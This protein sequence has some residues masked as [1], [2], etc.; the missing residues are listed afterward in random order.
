MGTPK[1]HFENVL[2]VAQRISSGENAVN[3]LLAYAR[4]VGREFAYEYFL[5]RIAPDRGA[6]LSPLMDLLDLA[7]DHGIRQ[8]PGAGELVWLAW[9]P[10]VTQPWEEFRLWDALEKLSRGPAGPSERWRFDPPN[11]QIL[12]WLPMRLAEVWN[13]MHSI[14]AGILNNSGVVPVEA[15]YDLSPLYERLT[16]PTVWGNTSENGVFWKEDGGSDEV[17]IGDWRLGVLFEIGRLLHQHG[18]DGRFGAS[19]TPDEL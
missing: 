16:Q 17:N 19:W 13:G 4:M 6:D 12:L 11:H 15:I 3:A 5:Y 8:E 10:V 1:E 2:H 7:E 9:D 18:F 14:A